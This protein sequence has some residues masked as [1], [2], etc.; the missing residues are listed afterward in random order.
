MLV[1][2]QKNICLFVQLN[3]LRL[4]VVKKEQLCLKF[5]KLKYCQCE[6][7]LAGDTGNN[8]LLTLTS[9]VPILKLKLTLTTLTVPL[10]SVRLLT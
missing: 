2:V 6:N 7:Q 8:L 3:S 9:M 5:K 1:M 10:K 4:P